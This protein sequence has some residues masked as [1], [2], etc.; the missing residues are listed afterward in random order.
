[1][2]ITILLMLLL[3]L[4]G[5]CTVVNIQKSD[6]NVLSS[7]AVDINN[8]GKKETLQIILVEGTK[9][10]DSEDVATAICRERI[11]GVF[12]GRVKFPNGRVVDTSLNHLMTIRGLPAKR[13]AFCIKPWKI[14]TTDYN[15]DGQTDFNLGQFWTSNGWIYWL[16]TISA[17]GQISV[18]PFSDSNSDNAVFL[19]DDK[20]STDH[21]EV[22]PGG[23]RFNYYAN[24]GDE[25]HPWGWW[26]VTFRW[27]PSN[28][29]FVLDREVHFDVDERPPLIGSP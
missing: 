25:G 8:D 17:S 3:A 11:E 29:V 1:M 10:S 24:V 9:I 6:A 5:G 23:I 4:S 12:A 14:F 18:L 7:Q 13:L 15:K 20:N 21:I 19:D 26:Q 2:K 22:V 27:N 28:N 16:F